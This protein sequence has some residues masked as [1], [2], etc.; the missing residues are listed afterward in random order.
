MRPRLLVWQSQK[1]KIMPIPASC[2]YPLNVTLS[3]NIKKKKKIGAII[4]LAG[5][6]LSPWKSSCAL[7]GEQRGARSTPDTGS[8]IPRPT[9]RFSS[10][11]IQNTSLRFLSKRNPQQLNYT[12]LYRKDSQGKFH[13][14]EPVKPAVK[15]Q[16]AVTDASLAGIMVKRN[17]KLEVRKAQGEQTLRAAKEAKEAKQASKKTAMR[18]P[19][20]SQRQYL[21]K[22]INT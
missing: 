14:K 21:D 7:S 12:V 5:L 20:P 3:V 13:R 9:G 8:T 10:F 1:L 18:V 16:G 11:L 4:S 22:Q 19:R 17:Q 15:F 6:Q 2:S